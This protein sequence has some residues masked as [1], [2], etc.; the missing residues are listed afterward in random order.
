MFE[1]SG[2]CVSALICLLLLTEV[3]NLIVYV[4]GLLHVVAAAVVACLHG[5]ALVLVVLTVT[6]E[7]IQLMS[8]LRLVDCRKKPSTPKDS[9]N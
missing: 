7:H 3:N 4:V 8:A 1:F 5:W 6:V 2:G 9:T